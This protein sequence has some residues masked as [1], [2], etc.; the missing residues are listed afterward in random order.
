M[1]C[2]L[3]T[4]D[5]DRRPAHVLGTHELP[6]G[7]YTFFFTLDPL[8]RPTARIAANGIVQA[9]LGARLICEETQA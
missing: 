6:S 2:W 1:T 8:G 3:E 5:G 7:V 4:N 9:E